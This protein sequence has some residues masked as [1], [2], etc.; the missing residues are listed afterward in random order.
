[1]HKAELLLDCDEVLGD[2]LSSAL[3]IISKHAKKEIATHHL[4]EWDIFAGLPDKIEKKCYRE[5][6]KKGFCQNIKPFE[7]AQKIM[8]TL[9]EEAEVYIVT[10]PLRSTYWH[11]ER[12][13]WLRTH[14]GIPSNRVILTS[15]KHMVQGDI[16]VDDRPLNIERWEQRNP[17][18]YAF[19]WDRPFNRGAKHLT[20]AKSW[21]DILKVV[22]SVNKTLNGKW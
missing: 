9:L 10:S 11:Q 5:F 21:K 19:L 7:D 18:R 16:F 4:T 1:M 22:R 17:G 2:F 3:P 6:S 20:R 15:A 13:D 12:V 14:M 8:P